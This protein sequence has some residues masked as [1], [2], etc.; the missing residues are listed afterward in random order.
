MKHFT[1][2][3]CGVTLITIPTIEF[4][5]YFLLTLISGGANELALT[6][7]QQAM[8]RAGH[9]H[10]GVLVILSLIAL[11]LSD[12]A[13]LPEPLLWLVR[14]G[15]PVAATLVSGGFFAAAIG[16]GLTQPNQ[17]I[18]LLYAGVALLAICLV[19]LGIGLLKKQA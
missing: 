9:G 6:D 13:R 1:R 18:I 12:H 4:G 3:L 5:G 11:I 8:F 15:F 7:F 19:T 17:W 10:A 2:V 14:I 16:E